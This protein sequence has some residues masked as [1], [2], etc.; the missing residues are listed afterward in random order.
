MELKQIGKFIQELRK[1]KGLT[2]QDLADL[3]PVSRETISKYEL[4]KN[5]PSE[6]VLIKL[7]DI[8]D[9]SFEELL[10]GARKNKKNKKEIEKLA[11]NLYHKYNKNKKNS[12]ILFIILIGVIILFL[13]YYFITTFNSLKVYYVGAKDSNITI[14]NG[15]MV[16]TRDKIYF[17]LGNISTD[18]EILSSRLYYKDRDEKEILIME[19]AE[20]V[21]FVDFLG[22]EEYIDFDDISY[23][24]DNMYVE[25]QTADTTKNL[26]IDFNKSFSNNT[27]FIKKA[28]SIGKDENSKS[29]NNL[30][31]KEIKK[32]I[33]D[34]FNLENEVYNYQNDNKDYFYFEEPN[35]LIIKIKDDN[36]TQE[37]NYYLNKQLIYEEYDSQYTILNSLIFKNNNINCNIDKCFNEEKI[38]KKFYE[39][40]DNLL[41]AF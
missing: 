11:Y 21:V 31:A 20:N 39:E 16:L 15:I 33:K 2:Q 17:N 22:Y 41:A 19:E 9:V 4:D 18:E 34:K 26:K 5:K 13:L 40:M 24:L 3:I 38:I 10:Y 30:E 36:K 12:I 23:I 6:D 28:E 8:F 35:L 25:I 27:L 37:Y 32:V 29:L 1:E 7:C 14:N